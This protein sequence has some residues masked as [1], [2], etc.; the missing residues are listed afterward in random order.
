MY[1]LVI[2]TAMRKV[3]ILS[4][5]DRSDG[6]RQ[7]LRLCSKLAKDDKIAAKYSEGNQNKNAMN[8]KY[9]QRPNKDKTETKS[10]R[11]IRIK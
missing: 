3:N 5:Q 9:N 6:A 10:N 4:Q 8:T 1:N 2:W 7:R 11:A